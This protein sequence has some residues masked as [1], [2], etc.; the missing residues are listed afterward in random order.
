LRRLVRS[1]AANATPHAMCDCP[2]QAQGRADGEHQRGSLSR[3]SGR[4]AIAQDYMKAPLAMLELWGS[5]RELF[6]DGEGDRDV[7][8]PRKTCC[9]TGAGAALRA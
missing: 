8:H 7:T 6:E 4:G 2:D 3:K 9:T 1:A 5:W